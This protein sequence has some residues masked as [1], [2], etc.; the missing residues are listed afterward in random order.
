MEITLSTINW[1]LLFPDSS[2]TWRLINE[3]PYYF[4]AAWWDTLAVSV[5]ASIS[6]LGFA[7]LLAVC[8]ARYQV[9]ERILL[10][11]IVVSQ[12]FPLQ[13]IAPL[14]VIAL[15]R[16][17]WTKVLIAF[18]IAFFPMFSVILTALKGIPGPLL[19]L[20]R[21]TGASYWP[22]VLLVHLP[23]VVPSIISGVKVAFTLAVLGAVVA[24]FVSPTSGI[25]RLLLVAQ[26]DYN[27]EVIYICIVMLAIQG[28]AMY[29]LVNA[30]EKSL[31]Y[32][33]R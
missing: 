15:G 18:I 31:I 21:V 12:S 27:V 28:L 8:A 23:A 5:A 26:S 32:K 1:T 16:S 30:I 14:I 22:S 17:E 29:A 33:W 25:G 20:C 24:E 4:L 3:Q 7:I 11:F 19:A 10:P 9:L 13:A 6:A 2:R